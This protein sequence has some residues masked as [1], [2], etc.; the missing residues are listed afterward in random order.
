MHSR[1]FASDFC[2]VLGIVTSDM[3]FVG[4]NRN[5]KL[6]EFGC[7]CLVEIEENHSVP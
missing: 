4:I 1:S 5:D 3:M 7:H 2:G 6:S